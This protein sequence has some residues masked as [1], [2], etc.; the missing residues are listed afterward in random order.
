VGKRSGQ[1]ESNYCLWYSSITIV[2][3]L[4]DLALVGFLNITVTSG[5]HAQVRVEGDIMGEVRRG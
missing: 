4:K 5:E 1:S 2:D 3:K